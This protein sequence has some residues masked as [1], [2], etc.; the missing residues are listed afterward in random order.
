[1]FKK[2][3]GGKNNGGIGYVFYKNMADWG[4]H[5]GTFLHILVSFE[6]ENI[7]TRITKD[8]FAPK[9]EAKRDYSL[10]LLKWIICWLV[11]INQ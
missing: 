3:I 11:F 2:W 7:H 5:S 1:L 8:F 9:K 4:L 10:Q 6:K